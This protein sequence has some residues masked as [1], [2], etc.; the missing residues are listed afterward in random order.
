MNGAKE[1]SRTGRQNF[2]LEVGL[3]LIIGWGLYTYSFQFTKGLGVT[4]L[5]KPVFWGIYIANFIFSVGLS[6][7]GIAVSA[8]VHILNKEEMKPVAI[9]AEMVSISFWPSSPARA[10][11]FIPSARPCRSP[12]MQI[13]FTILASCPAPFGPSSTQALA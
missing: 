7:G 2:W 12:A 8:L 13:W 10:A 1:L 9:I 4:G 11:K 6:A 5:N 3:V